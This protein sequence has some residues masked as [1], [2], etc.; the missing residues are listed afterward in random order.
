MNYTTMVKNSKCQNEYGKWSILQT[1][2]NDE[3]KGKPMD[4]PETKTKKMTKHK[5]QTTNLP[6]APGKITLLKQ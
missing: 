1:I 5:S 4:N 2:G 3:I 6:N